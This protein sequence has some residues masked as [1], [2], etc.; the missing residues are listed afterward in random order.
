MKSSAKEPWNRLLPRAWANESCNQVF[1][2]SPPPPRRRERHEKSHKL[3]GVEWG[4]RVKRRRGG[5]TRGLLV[6]LSPRTYFR[7]GGV[8][9]FFVEKS[10]WH[11]AFFLAV[12]NWAMKHTEEK[13]FLWDTCVCVTKKLTILLLKAVPFAHVQCRSRRKWVR[14]TNFFFK[15]PIFSFL[16]QAGHTLNAFPYPKRGETVFSSSSSLFHR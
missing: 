2:H 15:G 5:M 7:G 3:G 6:F 8:W 4:F 14:E 12:K 10:Q 1:L 11:K 9:G 16:E 13:T